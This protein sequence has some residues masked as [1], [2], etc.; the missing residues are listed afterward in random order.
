V[1]FN[2]HTISIDRITNTDLGADC[3][4]IITALADIPAENYEYAILIPNDRP[5]LAI[6]EG[7]PFAEKNRSH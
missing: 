5:L 7:H 2:H 1:Q 4:F 6:Y 3:D